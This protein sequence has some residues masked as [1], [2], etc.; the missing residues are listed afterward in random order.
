MS[1]WSGFSNACKPE[2]PQPLSAIL[3]GK[4]HHN[5]FLINYND[6]IRYEGCYPWFKSAAVKLTKEND[7]LAGEDFLDET[8]V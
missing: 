5:S 2:P 1:T 7:L 6:D 8:E 3:A 4:Y